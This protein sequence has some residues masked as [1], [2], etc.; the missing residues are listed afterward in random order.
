MKK[1]V[2]A[3]FLALTVIFMATGTVTSIA[4]AQEAPPEVP[5]DWIHRVWS[6]V[7]V[8]TP[9]AIIV[10]LANI[11]VGYLTKT[12]PEDFRLDYCVYTAMISFIVGVATI[13]F[14]WTYTQLQE[15]LGSGVL[16]WWI[17]RGAKVLAAKITAKKLATLISQPATGP[18]PP[19]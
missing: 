17:W 14:G 7:Q 10:A 4:Y 11:F 9:V 13:A 1:I 8:V 18:G 15:W 12:K 2:L 3:V 6:T 16:T 19:G 5:L